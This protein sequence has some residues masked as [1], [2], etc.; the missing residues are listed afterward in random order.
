MNTGQVLGGRG[1]GAVWWV[2]GGAVRVYEY[3]PGPGGK[4]QGSRVGDRWGSRACV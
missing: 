4:G 2:G 3:G 1:M